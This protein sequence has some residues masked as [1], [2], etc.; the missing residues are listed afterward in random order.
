ML[1]SWQYYLTMV[2]SSPDLA[3]GIGLVRMFMSRPWEIHW[4]VVKWL[5]RYI[6]GSLD[7]QLCYT[8]LKEF[9]IQGYC[10]LDFIADMDKKRST[11]GYEFTVGDNMVS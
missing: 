6:K 11:S 10:D 1:R 8:Q 3:Y 4:E 9:K 5:L 7:F 2:G